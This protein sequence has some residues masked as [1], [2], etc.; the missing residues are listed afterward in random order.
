[1]PRPEGGAPGGS[2]PAQPPA[3]SFARASSYAIRRSI[4]A[5]VWVEYTARARPA[6]GRA[7]TSTITRWRA[8]DSLRAWPTVNLAR[9]PPVASR[10]WGETVRS[11]PTLCEHASGCQDPCEDSGCRLGGCA[12]SCLVCTRSVQRTQ[13]RRARAFP[14]R[15]DRKRP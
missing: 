1:P 8:E 2:P 9:I 4:A 12:P 11:C 13:G 10:R 5:E 6:F 14:D 15:C 3:P 7:R